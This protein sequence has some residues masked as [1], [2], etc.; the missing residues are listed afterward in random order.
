MI[1]HT[2]LSYEPPIAFDTRL[3]FPDGREIAVSDLIDFVETWGHLERQGRVDSAGGA[4][5]C[6]YLGQVTDRR[7][8]A[9]GGVSAHLISLVNGSDEEYRSFWGS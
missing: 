8:P 6:G 3:T 4:E 9:T 2:T 1:E 7:H 5:F